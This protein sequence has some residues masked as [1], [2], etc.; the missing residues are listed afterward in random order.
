MQRLSLMAILGLAGCWPYISEPWDDH[1][2]PDEVQLLG[3]I[4]YDDLQGDYWSDPM[5]SGLAWWGWLDK[6]TTSYSTFDLLAAQEGC[7][8]VQA[9]LTPI[10]GLMADL[11]SPD[12]SIIQAGDKEMELSW[13]SS[14]LVYV[15][16]FK[17]N[18]WANDATY[19]LLPVDTGA[20]GELEQ[21]ELFQTPP[22]LEIEGSYEFDLA[23]W[24]TGKASELVFTWDPSLGDGD[25]WFYL[26]AYALNSDQEVLE[27]VI[28]MAPFKDGAIAMKANEY[29]TSPAFFY[30][31]WGP[32]W[33]TRTRLPDQ[34]VSSETITL[35]RRVGFMEKG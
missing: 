33:V 18:R 7:T 15:T 6:P 20:E 13:S 11:Q 26:E 9:D 8:Q 34:D 24:P 5:N 2:L 30:V 25:D 22:N 23:S 14:D 4:T 29:T 19:A 16:D 10:L 17:K 27:S 12:S 35:H 28:C 3:L 31:M 1:Y 21:P 32:A